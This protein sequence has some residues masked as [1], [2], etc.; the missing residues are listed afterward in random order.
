MAPLSKSVDA[1]GFRNRPDT[2]TTSNSPAATQPMEA[3]ALRKAQLEL[4]ADLRRGRV[5]LKTAIGP[6]P[7]PE[8]PVF[9][10]GYSLFGEPN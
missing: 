5:S 8:H 3:E 10:A 6:V 1:R 9:W 7:V 4:L 2:S